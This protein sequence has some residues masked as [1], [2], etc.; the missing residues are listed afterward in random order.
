MR[1]ERKMK[2]INKRLD[3]FGA[4]HRLR[5]AAIEAKAETEDVL[6]RPTV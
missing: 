5:V 2:A 3:A 6:I 4:L 1:R